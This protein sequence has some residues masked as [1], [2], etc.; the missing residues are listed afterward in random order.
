MGLIGKSFTSKL[1]NMT[2]LAISRIAILKNHRKAR[3]SY[4][5]S[6]V[7]QLLNLGYHDQALVRVEHWI[8]EQNML[9]AFVMIEDYC[10]VLR[11][12]AQVL[13]NN[14]LVFLISSFL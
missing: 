2:S 8:V 12:R 14:K 7:S 10:N 1:K 3:A 5:F 13:E 11:E 6:D 4:A 9:D